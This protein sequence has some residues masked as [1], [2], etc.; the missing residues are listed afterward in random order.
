[1]WNASVHGNSLLQCVN[2]LAQL[3]V[4][5]LSRVRVWGI[6]PVGNVLYPTRPIT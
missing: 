3:E 5:F 6:Q 2:N 1:M 4:V